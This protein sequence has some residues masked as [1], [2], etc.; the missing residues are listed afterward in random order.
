MLNKYFLVDELKEQSK[1]Q[2]FHVAEEL[3]SSYIGRYIAAVIDTEYYKSTFNFSFKYEGE[4]LVDV[5]VLIYADSKFAKFFR[6]YLTDD[7]R[8]RLTCGGCYIRKFDGMKDMDYVK[9]S[10]YDH[11]A[12]IELYNDILYIAR[13]F[14]K[15]IK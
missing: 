5:G 11:D 6:L 8:I 2:R 3:F 14:F 15:T 10:D 12:L 4:E 7:I 13:E 1:R 9:V